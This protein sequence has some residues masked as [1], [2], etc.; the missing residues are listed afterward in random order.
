MISD[1]LIRSDNK[2]GE[3]LFPLYKYPDNENKDLFNAHQTKKEPNIAPVVFEKLGNAYGKSPTP[4][5]ILYYI[6]GVFYSNVYRERY[7]EFL[8]IDFP[9][10]P[11]TSNVELF[12][13]LCLIGQKLAYL[14]LMKAEF[15][16]PKVSFQG[17]QDDLKKNQLVQKIEYRED[18]VY[19][20]SSQYFYPVPRKVW[21]FMIGGYQVAH[22][23]LKDRKDRVHDDGDPWPLSDLEVKT[24]RYII[25]ALEQTDLLMNEIDR[26][27]GNHGGW[28]IS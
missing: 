7:A 28:P 15:D 19:I 16:N 27:I 26:L 14:H 17:F 23:W 20:N 22:K 11:V 3:S 25:T 1:G 18:K 8:K 5:E 10:I 13:E 2:G 6:Y 9:H 12:K 4:E 24:Y 21:E